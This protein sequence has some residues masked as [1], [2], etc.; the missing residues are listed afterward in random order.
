MKRLG[1]LIIGIVIGGL[2]A[3]DMAYAQD[4]TVNM[5]GQPVNPAMAPSVIPSNNK[6]NCTTGLA[7]SVSTAVVGVA[8]GSA[9]V[10][11]ECQT[12][13]RAQ[14]VHEFGLTVAAVSYLC[15]KDE[16]LQEAMLLAGS[17]CPAPFGTVSDDAFNYWKIYPKTKV[18][19]EKYEKAVPTKSKPV[20]PAPELLNQE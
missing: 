16:T 5:K 10:E 9:F 17:P 2:L 7:G 19:F 1:L 12:G 20:D 6:F 11:V 18:M 15:L 3:F 13:V 14:Q 4:S 8:I